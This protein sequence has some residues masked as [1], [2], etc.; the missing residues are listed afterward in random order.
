[1]G[2]DTNG[3]TDVF[4]HDRDTDGDGQYDEP[5]E[6]STVRVSVDSAGVEGDDD[7]NFPSI[8]S[9]GRYVA[10]ESNADNLVAS[11]NGLYS[12]VFVHDLQTGE[13][14]RVSVDLDG[15]E[16]NDNSNAPSMSADGKSVT[17]Q[18]A[19]DNLVAGDTNL[20]PDI[21]FDDLPAAGGGG[22]SN[23]GGGGCFISTAAY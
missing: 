17:F 16:G 5:G 2:N 7:S 18:S 15:V 6:V 10:F 11:D 13:T 1:M 4:V 14:T 8:S 9:D 22:G 12:D 3:S 20:A 23:S 21:F 19:A